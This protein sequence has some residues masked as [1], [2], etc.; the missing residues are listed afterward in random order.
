MCE[1]VWTPVGGVCVTFIIESVYWII[2]FLSPTK[3]LGAGF[4]MTVF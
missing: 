4:G 2:S 1:H 3:G